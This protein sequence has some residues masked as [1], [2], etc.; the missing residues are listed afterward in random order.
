L[1]DYNNDI[2][3]QQNDQNDQNYE[4]N[5]NDVNVPITAESLSIIMQTLPFIDMYN[6]CNSSHPPLKS[7]P[8]THYPPRS[9]THSQKRLKLSIGVSGGVDSLSS[10]ILLS[11][12]ATQHNNIVTDFWNSLSTSLH[13][14][15][16][17]PNT[18]H[19][20]HPHSSIPNLPHLSIHPSFIPH[21]SKLQLNNFNLN[22]DL[23]THNILVDIHAVTVNHGLRTEAYN[24]TFY[25]KRFCEEICQVPCDVINIHMGMSQKSDGDDMNDIYYVLVSNFGKDNNRKLGPNFAQNDQPGQFPQHFSKR[26]FRYITNTASLTSTHD[27]PTQFSSKLSPSQ[28]QQS[29]H[30]TSIETSQDSPLTNSNP[31]PTPQQQQQQQQQQ[32]PSH[33]LSNSVQDS[34]RVLRYNSIFNHLIESGSAGYITGHHLLDQHETILYRL[35]RGSGFSG[36]QGMDTISPVFYHQVDN[37]HYIN[38]QLTHFTQKDVSLDSFGDPVKNQLQ[39]APNEFKNKPQFFEHSLHHK[40]LPVIRPFLTFTRQGLTETFIRKTRTHYNHYSD[41]T[42]T[43]TNSPKN[44][45]PKQTLQTE[46]NNFQKYPYP[47]NGWLEDPS[48]KD[49]HYDRVKIRHFLKENL[50]IKY[51]RQNSSIY[52]HIGT[53]A[54]DSILTALGTMGE[55]SGDFHGNLNLEEVRQGKRLQ[56]VGEKNGNIS[57]QDQNV[58]YHNDLLGGFGIQEDFDTSLGIDYLQLLS[59]QVHSIVTEFMTHH[60]VFN[61]SLR[62]CTVTFPLDSQNLISNDEFEQNQNWLEEFDKN[63]DGKNTQNDDSTLLKRHNLI[64][65]MLN[66]PLSLI[67]QVLSRSIAIISNETMQPRHDHVAKVRQQLFESVWEQMD[68]FAKNNGSYPLNINNTPYPPHHHNNTTI[69]SQSSQSQS[70]SDRRI[71]D[72]EGLG[73]R[74][75]KMEKINKSNGQKVLPIFGLQDC[76]V[77]GEL[78]FEAL[79]MGNKLERVPSED[80]LKSQ[81]NENKRRKFKMDISN[82]NGN[83]IAIPQDGIIP[84]KPTHFVIHL[85]YGYPT[86]LNKNQYKKK[87]PSETLKKKI[88]SENVLKNS[89][90]N[91]ILNNNFSSPSSLN[92][93]DISSSLILISF[94]PNPSF[95]INALLSPSQTSATQTLPITFSPFRHTRKDLIKEVVD[96]VDRN[97]AER[98]NEINFEQTK[99]QFDFFH[100]TNATLNTPHCYTR[101]PYTSNIDKISTN[102]INNIEFGELGHNS[103]SQHLP[104]IPLSSL[105]T[106]TPQYELNSSRFRQDTLLNSYTRHLETAARKL[107]S[108]Q[109][110]LHTYSFNNDGS[111]HTE[112]TILVNFYPVKAY[113]S[114]F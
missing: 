52:H 42:H 34:A 5:K 28:S 84:S 58:E 97:Y 82:N 61:S 40:F 43:S 50:P 47:L 38:T 104:S 44:F 20:Q 78:V 109:P 54:L 72:G 81:K 10:T 17:P 2:F 16:L 35:L 14:P 83:L 108:I 96:L 60:V 79:P 75:E 76:R 18:H 33:Q 100:T 26:T 21:F 63:D 22:F 114:L 110:S 12:W 67:D 80:E 90:Q 36:L 99:N 23:L 111:E 49:E 30:L 87:L 73:G 15:P 77:W 31:A 65:K 41:N 103:E 113:K 66:I 102:A 93:G 4:F 59:K 19:D 95:N 64:P 62:Q 24:E 48:N 88:Q 107:S 71:S 39:Q 7:N 68:E 74:S 27:L 85:N 45:S 55:E 112:A 11:Q 106:S 8:L 91:L 105:P 37:N 57:P 13:A 1:G 53:S 29:L 94:S 9:A 6:N 98:L 92:N 25:V 69:T 86:P 51:N 101:R 89:P 70:D 3:P 46:G 56:F 32:Q